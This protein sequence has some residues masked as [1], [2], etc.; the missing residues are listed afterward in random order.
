VENIGYKVVVASSSVTAIVLALPESIQDK[1]ET[2]EEGALADNTCP[3]VGSVV[4]IT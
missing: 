2:F 1:V 4:G 3:E